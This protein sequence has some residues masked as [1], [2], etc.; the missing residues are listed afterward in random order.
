MSGCIRVSRTGVR[1]ESNGVQT[2]QQ[3]YAQIIKV[4]TDWANHYLDKAKSK[5]NI[6]DLQSDLADGV[7]LSD[8]VETICNHRLPDVNRKPRTHLQMLGNIKSC[9][10]LLETLGVPLDGI[11]AHDVKEG[12][13]K[14]ILGLFFALSKYK[15]K[16]KQQQKSEGPCKSRIPA[17]DMKQSRLPGPTLHS[18][19]ITSIPTPFVQRFHQLQ[20]T[21][22]ANSPYTGIKCTSN[23][24]SRSTSPHTF[25]P[26]PKT[27]IRTPVASPK[28]SNQ[29][30]G[31][32]VKTNI[33][34]PYSS[35]QKN[36]A[37]L[38]KLKA[39]NQKEKSSK[40][41]ISNTKRTSSSS[42]FSSA[43]SERSDSSNSLSNEPKAVPNQEKKENYTDVPK[44][45]L[46]KKIVRPPVPAESRLSK[47][48]IKSTTPP[49]CENLQRK[50]VEILNSDKD[51]LTNSST[52]ELSQS[53][54]VRLSGTGIPKPVAT[55]KGM[56]KPTHCV[57]PMQQINSE[58]KKIDDLPE[59]N[60][61][62][63]L[64]MCNEPK[65]SD[66]TS[67]LVPNESKHDKQNSFTEEDDP[68]LNV[69]PMEPLLRGYKRS[70]IVP[71]HRTIPSDL[72]LSQNNSMNSNYQEKRI[73]ADSD[74]GQQSS[75]Y[76]SDGDV[77]QYD[78]QSRQILAT[79]PGYMSE[80]PV[81]NDSKSIKYQNSVINNKHNVPLNNQIHLKHRIDS[82]DRL[83][84]NT[85]DPNQS[86]IKQNVKL[87]RFNMGPDGGS[88]SL[89]PDVSPPTSPPEPT[90]V[91]PVYKVVTRN[92]TKKLDSGQQ[93]ELNNSSLRQS[94]QWKKYIEAGKN[95]EQIRANEFERVR[96]KQSPRR[97]DKKRST[98][99][100]R[101]D[102]HNMDYIE[103]KSRSDKTKARGSV[104][105]SF[106]YVKRSTSSSNS[107]SDPRTAQVSAVPRTKVKVSGGT[108]TDMKTY[109]VSGPSA[110]QLSQNVRERLMANQSEQ[111]AK[112]SSPYGT[113]MRHSPVP[114]HYTASLPS[115]TGAIGGMIE[116]DSIESLPA[117]LH[118]RAS[119]THSRLMSTASSNASPSPSQANRISRSNS[120]SYLRDRTFPRSTKSEKLYPSMLQRSDE[121]DSYYSI[122]YTSNNRSEHRTYPHVSQPTSPTPTN[123]YNY[124]SPQPNHRSVISSPYAAS[125]MS[126]INTKDDD[127]HGS[128]LSLISTGSSSL[129]SGM[130]V[131]E[132]QAHE[133][134][135]LR[136]DLSD[137]Q[138]KVHTLTSQLSTNAHVVSAFEQSL[139]NM[140]QRLQ[141]LTATA[142]KKDHELHELR[143]TIEVLR[144]QSADSGNHHP[145]GNHQRRHTIN[146][147]ADSST[148]SVSSLNSL[149]SACSA[150]SSAQQSE[151]DKKKKRGWLRSSFSKAFSRSK[152]NRSNSLSDAEEAHIARN[153]QN[154]FLSDLS[155]PSSPMLSTPHMNGL[156][157]KN[158]HSS[159]TS[160]YD[161][162]R[163]EHDSSPEMVEQLRKQLREKDLVLT[164]IRLEALSSAHQLESLKDTVIKMRD[165]MLNLKQD[166]ERLQKIV[167][168]QSLQS[169]CSSLQSPPTSNN[170]QSDEMAETLLT[171]LDSDAM[172][173]QVSVYLGSH[174]SYTKF[175][176]NKTKACVISALPISP[177]SK[178]DMVDQLVI[179]GFKDYVERI[180]PMT[181]LGLCVDSL[182]SYHVEDIIRYISNTTDYK[183]PEKSPYECMI[184]GSNI[185]ICLKGAM[186][187]S[188]SLDALAFDT[189]IPKSILQRYVSL[190]SEHHRIIL[191]GPSG[192]GK[193]YLS[194]K[195]AEFLVMKMG[196]ECNSSTIVTFSV[197]ETN[198]KDLQ[199]YLSEI[200][201][202]ADCDPS[203]IPCVVILDNL[204][205]ALSLPDV[206]NGFQSPKCPYIIGTINQSTCSTTSLQLHH[207]FRWVLCA[208]HME[209]MKGFLGRHLRRK[210]VEHECR[211]GQRNAQL[212][213]VVEWIP[214]VRNHLNQLLETH[215]SSEVT[216]GPVLFVTCPMDLE[217]SQMWFSD[218]WN[219]SL[220][221]YVMDMVREGIKLY[222]KRAAW[223]DPASFVI[224]SY[225]WSNTMHKTLESF[226]RIRPEDVGYDMEPDH[227]PLLNMLMTLQ[228]AANY[229]SP[230]NDTDM[231]LPNSNG[232]LA[233]L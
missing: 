29:K 82:F 55:V 22:S 37:L 65:K 148:D 81:Y 149:S 170:A 113:W 197:D 36:S 172:L 103:R 19:S 20:N 171:S 137:A 31:M 96:D 216:L 84:A 50:S 48:S 147:V 228:E 163:A 44:P 165:E 79:D 179:K 129:Y 43:R 101:E 152:K 117:Q 161:C 64:D 59:K 214:E 224:Q 21:P 107:K 142:E 131:D 183:P 3:Q 143:Q 121:P 118:H 15:Q 2:H 94:S 182:W 86:A 128:A 156:G 213:R 72:G 133:I 221:P 97:T 8:L 208:N 205:K 220:V 164:D 85:N 87:N 88:S 135:R 223:K 99:G 120:I 90:P 222:G 108:Q 46:R 231:S 178:W 53:Q 201:D 63:S 74:Y 67:R 58:S 200:S 215:S 151:A 16:Q 130:G 155:A 71:Q 184:N 168:N 28:N 70:I 195:L 10:D 102:L 104:P 138:D 229:S 191:C 153:H 204:H 141:Q 136:R 17:T 61:V 18:G 227:D 219:Y 186:H 188:G 39:S 23:S 40:Q 144:K 25:I 123:R 146:S 98:D 47:I 160:L 150:S 69:K 51:D 13:L 62:K 54:S 203:Q 157:L 122:P 45:V 154:A 95:A 206:F 181:K 89:G 145:N 109:S 177:K 26:S 92:H 226:I 106:G 192:T 110:T 189:L 176:E 80:G 34:S 66:N 190:L 5:K 41:V 210:L 180:D 9:L 35:A 174:G 112:I 76:V 134:R 7:L 11:T 230:Q 57:A 225:P 127:A 167:T 38:E 30:N 194:N 6:K 132:K 162:D 100:S 218:L 185:F 211:L 140:T 14:A 158:S 169:S 24:S 198:N 212:K 166:N 56:A 12:N 193:S 68:A 33:A 78:I 202:K 187:S 125:I 209:P 77:L 115:R 1:T 173:I 49:K 105:Q 207:N 114:P 199:Q 73:S 111:E 119:L 91:A 60:N 233:T 196:K 139:S 4:Y 75:G 42:G 93:T 124:Q 32:P 83:D 27:I 126:K 159:T 232:T 175:K 217:T 116:A 52:M